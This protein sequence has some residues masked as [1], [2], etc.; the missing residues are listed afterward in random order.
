MGDKMEVIGVLAGLCKISSL[1][2][3]QPESLNYTA[4]L[5]G[6]INT[7]LNNSTSIMHFPEKN[8]Y[9]KAIETGRLYLG[10]GEFNTAFVKGAAMSLDE[11]VNYAL[12][13]ETP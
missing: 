9:E 1:Q 5:G 11:V 7:L 4:R 2:T 10:A 3:N 12:T 8:Y 6:A 13:L